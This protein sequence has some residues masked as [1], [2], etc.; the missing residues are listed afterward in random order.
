VL[1]IPIGRS[2]VRDIKH[3]CTELKQEEIPADL[4]RLVGDVLNAAE[5][6]GEESSLLTSITNLCQLAEEDFWIN[7][8][9]KLWKYVLLG[10]APKPSKQNHFSC[11]PSYWL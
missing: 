8:Y 5:P 2:L 3:E 1:P 6:K 7:L 4:E 10:P 9:D 11:L